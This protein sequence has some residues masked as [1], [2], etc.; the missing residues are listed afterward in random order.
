VV[1]IYDLSTPK[2]INETEAGV[3]STSYKPSYPGVCNMAEIPTKMDSQRLFSDLY[4][5]PQCTYIDTHRLT[6][7]HTHMHTYTHVH[8]H[9]NKFINKK[10]KIRSVR[11]RKGH[12]SRW[13]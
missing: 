8:T 4:I 12:F 9:K 3:P 6:Y 2:A 13:I 7:I 10:N 1:H 11:G 5:L